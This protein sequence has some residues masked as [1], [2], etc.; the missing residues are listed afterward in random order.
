MVQNPGDHTLYNYRDK[1]F[2]QQ[3]PAEGGAAVNATFDISYGFPGSNVK[4]FVGS[5][6]IPPITAL[7]RHVL[8]NCR[9]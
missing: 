7:T 3:I 6:V 5:E 4:G 1:P 8:K 2:L 9:L